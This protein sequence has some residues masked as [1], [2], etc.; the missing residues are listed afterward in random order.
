[1]LN[2]SAYANHVIWYILQSRNACTIFLCIYT[3]FP[4]SLILNSE[5]AEC[6]I[7]ACKSHFGS[8]IKHIAWIKISQVTFQTLIKY[9]SYNFTFGSDI[10]FQ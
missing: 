2:S 8:I 7:P 10:L 9:S 4:S 1:M 6:L 3:Y 5:N